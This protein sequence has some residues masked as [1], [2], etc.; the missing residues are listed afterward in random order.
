MTAHNIYIHVPF[1]ASKCKYC[2]FYSAAITP[3]WDKYCDEICRE[4]EYWGMRLNHVGVPTIFFGGG[5]PSLMPVHV[6]AKIINTIQKNF[7]IAP[8]AEI[9]IESNP[10]TI[11]A[12]KLDDFIAAGVNRISIG[13]QALDDA[14]LNFL[15]RRHS[16]HDAITLINTAMARNLRTNADFI[17]GIPGQTADDVAAMARAINNLGLTHASMYELTIEE[18]TPFGKMNLNMPS[19][20]EMAEMYDA[21]GRTLSLPRYEVSNYATP[22][23]ECRHNANIWDGAPYVGIGRAAAGRVLI[24]NTWYQQ[25]GGG[26]EFLP[27]QPRDR[28]IEKVITGMRTMRGVELTG[29]VCDVIDMDFAK[30]NSQ[31][32]K[33]SDNRISA[34][35]DGI[36]ILDNLMIDLVR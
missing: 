7:H 31:Y 26:A 33:I 28:A 3:N 23:Q 16:A 17:Y 30:Q 34:T 4:I 8:N 11:D 10:G 25:R 21:I 29:D 24:D 22:G 12:A 1:C 20:D 13:V 18:N 27:M 32:I 36:L 15:G 6:F 5:T 2:A 19:N 35:H 9:T 14:T